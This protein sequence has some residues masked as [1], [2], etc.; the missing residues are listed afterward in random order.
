MNVPMYVYIIFFALIYMG[1]NRCFSRVIKL[2]RLF[3]APLF[4]TL[5]SIRGMVTLFDIQIH[6]VTLWVIGCVIGMFLGY[7]H[8][9]NRRVKADHKQQL[10]QLPGDWSMLCL[11]LAIFGFEFFVHY[12]I[13]AQWALASTL[14]FKSTSLIILGVI[15]GMSSGRT[16]NYFLKY[17]TSI[18]ED[19]VIA[20]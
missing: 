1:I 20:S 2:R 7:I 5:L 9:Q 12:S 13:D 3:V 10:I 16:L 14:L 4:F 17:K 15:A 11:I 18:S 19:L 8:V 6:D